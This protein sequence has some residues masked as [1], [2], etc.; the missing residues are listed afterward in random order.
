MSKPAVYIE[1]TIAGHLTSRLPKDPIVAGQMLLTRDWWLNRRAQYECFT[2]Q[3]VLEEA[4]RGDPAAVA[5]R[6]AA[7]AVLPI[8]EPADSTQVEDLAG[9]LLARGALPAKARVDSLHLATAAATGMDYLLTW[10]CRHLANAATRARIEAACRDCG[11]EPP[12]I[13]TPA[14]LD[15]DIP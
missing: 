11:F 1:T 3:R 5:E 6:L 4:S 9:L 12:L 15:E 8:V 2:S 14:E 13:C 7:L 10:N